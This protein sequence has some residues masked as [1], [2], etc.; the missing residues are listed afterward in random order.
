ML[1]RQPLPESY[2]RFNADHHAPYGRRHRRLLT[3]LG[4][5][6]NP[7]VLRY[8]TPYAWQTN[9]TI[10]RFEYP[11]VYERIQAAGRG[12]RILDIGAGM[13]GMQFTL[14]QAGHEVHAI[15]PGMSA[16]G[17]GWRLDPGFHA[18][19]SKAYS[20]PVTLWSTTMAG[21]DLQEES[22]DVVLSVSTIEHFAPED[23]VEFSRE[24]RRLLKPG[25][26]LVLTIDLFI[27]VEPFTSRTSNPYGRNI[28]VKALLEDCG[29]E[30]VEGLPAELHGFAGFDP[31]R[32]QANLSSYMVGEGYPGLTQCLVARILP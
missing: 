11:W 5:R 4:G 1:A 28:D 31:N 20:A 9:N 30:L 21:A 26:L 17:R 3:C 23:L 10:R 24:A 15:D 25:G 18:R 29:A 6:R 8:R 7:L 16:K 27:D 13:A 22:F 32:I 14:A 12:L 2:E 19:L